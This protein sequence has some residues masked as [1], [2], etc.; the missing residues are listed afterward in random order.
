MLRP[1]PQCLWTPTTAAEAPPYTT[2]L[3]A[4]LPDENVVEVR[5]A[6][7][8]RWEALHRDVEHP[9]RRGLGVAAT[10]PLARRLAVL[11]LMAARRSAP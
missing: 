3:D 6:D 9:S 10:E 11:E 1:D 8:G 4:T 5:R 7:G 2:S